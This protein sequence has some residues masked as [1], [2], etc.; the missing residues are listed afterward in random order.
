MDFGGHV[1]TRPRE[2]LRATEDKEPVKYSEAEPSNRGKPQKG[3]EEESGDSR[4]GGGNIT[5]GGPANATGGMETTERV[6]QGCGRTSAAAR[7][8]Y[9]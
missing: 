3:Q 6:V 9:A 4:R 1:E 7:S 5:W 2:S 8:S